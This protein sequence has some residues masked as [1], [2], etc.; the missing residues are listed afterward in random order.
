MYHGGYESGHDGIHIIDKDS[1]NHLKSFYYAL[2]SSWNNL[3]TNWL[4]G[5]VEMANNQILMIM[6]QDDGINT[7]TVDY[8]GNDF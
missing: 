8:N 1:G 3:G 6:N 4:G 5:S 7:L 2:D